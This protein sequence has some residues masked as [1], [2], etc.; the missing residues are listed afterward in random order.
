MTLAPDAAVQLPAERVDEVVDVIADAF[1]GYPL[2]RWVAGS[3]GTAQELAARERRLVDLF[4]RRRIRRG[5]PAFGVSRGETLAAAAILTLPHEPEPPADV[6][7]MTV[8][9]W[10]DLGDDARRRYDA[11]TK[12]ATFFEALPP[13]HHLNMIGVRPAHKRQ[14]LARPL[15]EAVCGLAEA[16]PGSHGVSLTT[17]VAINIELYRHFGFEV[18]AEAHV[19]PDLKTWGLFQRIG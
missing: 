15:I 1:F 8:A 7:E 18:I 17:E 5:G 16:D 10:L 4:V 11:Y 2:M 13:H 6:A 19:T 12:A 3:D 9:T 14:G